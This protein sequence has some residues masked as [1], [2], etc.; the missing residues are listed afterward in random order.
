MRKFVFSLYLLILLFNFIH[1]AP[2]INISINIED[3]VNTQKCYDNKQQLNSGSEEDKKI[4]IYELSNNSTSNTV[5][6]Q[7]K[8]IR[9][10]VVSESFQDDSSII[11]KETSKTGSYYLN[12]NSAKSK[13]YVVIDNDSNPH[14]ICFTSFQEKGKQ[15]IHSDKNINIKLASYDILSSSK[16]SFQ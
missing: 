6:I 16:L 9:N 12:M 13:Y 15:F 4:T 5:F 1:P 14:K 2:K 10:F 8:S 3:I 7:Y 11:Y